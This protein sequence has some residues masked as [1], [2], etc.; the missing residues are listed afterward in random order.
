MIE[1]SAQGE[2][3]VQADI[4]GASPAEGVWSSSYRFLT[5]GLLLTIVAAAFEQLS[6]ATTMPA[7]VNDLGGLALY[8]WAFSAFMLMMIIGL[9]FGGSEADRLGP[10]RPFFGGALL[11]G[12]G[13]VVAGLA[14]SMP[15]LIVGRAIQGLGAGFVSA[16]A[17]AVIGRDYPEATRPRMLALISS[18]YILPSLTG[19]ALAGLIADYF[20]WRWIF[21]GLA[22]LLPL[23]AGSALFALRRFER[24]EAGPRDWG[25]LR[26]AVFLAAGTGLLMSGLGSYQRI[27]L[28]VFLTGS[29]AVLVVPAIRR[30][31]PA[32]S[33]QSRGL[34]AALGTGLL[35]NMAFFGADA[36]VPLMLT[37]VRNQTT[38]F[39]GFVITAA[40]VSWI[41][42]AWL[43]AQLVSH[44]S[45]RT[46]VTIG[47]GLIVAGIVGL[48]VALQPELPVSLALLAWGIAGAGMGFASPTVT[49]IAMAL[50]PAGQE[51]ATTSA[52]GQG[53]ILGIALGAG[54]GG[55]IVGQTEAGSMISL[56]QA[57][58]HL[59]LM[60][61]MVLIALVVA[62]RLP[63]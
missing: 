50:A 60:A 45:R 27:P 44:R 1:T 31:L 58:G 28:A 51:G 13:L 57:T 21:L 11:F 12:L 37:A 40:T 26:A 29:G 52:I 41:A 30:L 42:S 23:A 25:Q 61:G 38:S 36:F 10:F 35:L 55:I 63:D 19:P 14:P 8:G 56:G 16:I 17:Y 7:A 5:L 59:L 47:L 4:A 20:G 39:A 62:R 48:G 24:P 22:P 54:I 6:V 2:R 9:T 49:L 32:G 18:A 15:V 43:Q 33:P 3:T 46:L 53:S 34:F